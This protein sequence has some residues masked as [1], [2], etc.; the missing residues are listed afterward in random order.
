MSWDILKPVTNLAD[1][2][3]SWEGIVDLALML[4]CATLLFALYDDLMLLNELLPVFAELMIFI[5]AVITFVVMA[6]ITF[7][8]E[9]GLLWAI[10]RLILLI[11]IFILLAIEIFSTIPLYLAVSAAVAALLSFSEISADYGVEYW[12]EMGKDTKIGF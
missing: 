1:N 4:T 7:L 6:I 10:L 8:L 9:L 5:I 12:A 11:F 3:V 2:G